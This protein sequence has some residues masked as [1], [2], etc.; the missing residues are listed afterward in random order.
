VVVSLIG[1]EQDPQDLAEQ[2]RLLEETGATV[3]SVNSQAA[4]FAAMLVEPACRQ[5][6]LEKTR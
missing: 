4:R 3:F 6:F 1:T 2:R 5:T